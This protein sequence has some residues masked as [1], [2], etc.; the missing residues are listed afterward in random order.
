MRRVDGNNEVKMTEM[1][2]RMYA[3][4]TKIPAESRQSSK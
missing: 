3:S 4:A 1:R 2:E